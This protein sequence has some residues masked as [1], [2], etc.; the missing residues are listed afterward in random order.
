MDKKDYIELH[1][2]LQEIYET[3]T[4]IIAIAD[5]IAYQKNGKTRPNHRP[6]RRKR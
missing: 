2:V 4:K 1:K 5:R 3:N 6:E